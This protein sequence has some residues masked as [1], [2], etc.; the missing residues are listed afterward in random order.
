MFLAT[1]G[2]HGR[3]SR[4]PKVT[5]QSS[6]ETVDCCLELTVYGEQKLRR[7]TTELTSSIR[8]QFLHTKEVTCPSRMSLR[9]KAKV[10]EKAEKHRKTPMK[11]EF[12]KCLVCSVLCFKL[13]TTPLL[14]IILHTLYRKG[15][16]GIRRNAMVLCLALTSKFEQNIGI[17]MSSNGDSCMM[18]RFHKFSRT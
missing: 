7:L 14:S 13:P 2:T 16:R 8:K 18:C 10:Y 3:T 5:D 17:A 9:A 1:L 6:K 12:G 15:S 4:K 11:M